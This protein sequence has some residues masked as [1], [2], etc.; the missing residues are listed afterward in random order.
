MWPK[1]S[2]LL[3]VCM[4]QSAEVTTTGRNARKNVDEDRQHWVDSGPRCCV[5]AAAEA[6]AC[7]ASS[8]WLN[9]PLDL[10]KIR[11]R[12]TGCVLVRQHA[13]R[14]SMAA[15]A[16][17]L[18]L[19]ALAMTSGARAQFSGEVGAHALTSPMTA[20]SAARTA[21]ATQLGKCTQ[22]A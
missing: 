8:G 1:T 13:G 4:I 7:S 15:N 12:P 16:V 5:C 21:A 20:A 2:P 11:N 18:G 6:K 19:I 3:I 10:H 14:D 9:W 17:L 22:P